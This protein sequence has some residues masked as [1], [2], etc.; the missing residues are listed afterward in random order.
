MKDVTWI[1]PD[2]EEMKD[3]DWADSENRTLGMLLYGRAVDEIDARGRSARGETLLLLLNAGMRPRPYT[4]PR[5]SEPGRWEEL[6]DTARP[7]RFPRTVRGH[8]VNLAAQSSLLLRR[9][10]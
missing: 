5:V 7:S 10:E 8:A 6:V 9:T 2:G 3:E 1:R 4:L